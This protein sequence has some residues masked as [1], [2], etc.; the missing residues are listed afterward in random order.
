MY[1]FSWLNLFFVCMRA[2]ACGGQESTSGV[3]L[4]VL[5]HLGFLKPGLLLVWSVQ[6]QL[7]WLTGD[8]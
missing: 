1:G 4:H 6:I 7:D 3:T 5:D 8:P 2:L